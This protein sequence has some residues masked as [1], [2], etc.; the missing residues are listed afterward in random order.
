MDPCFDLVDALG[1]LFVVEKRSS[2]LDGTIP[3]RAA[4]GCQPLLEG[5]SVG[6][7]IR[8]REPARIRVGRRDPVLRFSRSVAN[9]LDGTYQDQLELLVT[10][11]L[12][13][14]GGF[15]HRWLH[16][17]LA[18]AREGALRIWTG[19]L[20]RPAPGS[21]ILVSRAYNR[22]CLVGVREYVVPDDGGWVPVML[23]FE[24]LPR[25]PPEVWLDSEVATMAPLSPNVRVDIHP[26][27]AQ[28]AVGMTFRDFYRNRAEAKSD[29]QNGRYRRLV[30][31]IADIP[32]P[33]GARCRIVAG[34]RMAL[35]R[36]GTFHRFATPLG[37]TSRHV[38]RHRLQFATIGATGNVRARWDGLGVRFEKVDVGAL[39][40]RFRK[41]WAKL[42]GQ[43]SLPAA[44]WITQ[45]APTTPVATRGEPYFILTPFVFSLTPPGWSCMVDGADLGAGAIAGLRGVVA[46]DCYGG[47]APVYHCHAPLRFEVRQG[48]PIARLLP[49]PRRLLQAPIRVLHAREAARSEG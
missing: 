47:I 4:R 24:R 14:S 25:S 11:G 5:N 33:I 18:Q 17:G 26:L 1:G 28:P 31:D 13:A 21:W 32:Y 6:F 22:R 38:G 41:R 45:F 12:I 7:Q 43:A 27:E 29:E 36:V 15:W 49:V 30:A 19:L 37:L 16:R 46:T 39:A 8:L 20:V 48:A 42:Y 34:D 10:S 9:H 35:H 2:T 23:E 44:E 3:L 40:E